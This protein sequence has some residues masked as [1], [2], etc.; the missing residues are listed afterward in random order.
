MN[1]SL[2]TKVIVALAAQ[3]VGTASE[4]GSTIDMQDY[5]GIMFIAQFGAV[6]DGSPSIKAQG[7]ALANGSDAADLAGTS[8]GAAASNKACVLD[9]YRPTQRYITPVVTRGGSTGAVVDGVIAILYGAR[10]KPT[11]LD[12]SVSALETWISPVTG[13]A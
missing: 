6:T 11:A 2:A 12:S 7:G 4:T 13:T 9:I 3:A 10:T 1:L 8:T 5:D